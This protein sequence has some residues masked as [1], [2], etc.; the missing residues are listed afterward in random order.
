MAVT[1]VTPEPASP[2]I[3]SRL[4]IR[5]TTPEGAAPFAGAAAAALGLVWLVYERVLPFTGVLGFWVCWYVTFLVL[6]TVMARLQWDRLEARNRLAA[7]ALGTRRG[8]A[9]LI[10]VAA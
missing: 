2:A 9:A 3:E 8:R 6:Y 10:L 1:T 4:R 5:R 7:G